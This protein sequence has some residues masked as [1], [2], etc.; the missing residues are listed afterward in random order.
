MACHGPGGK[1]DMEPA[2]QGGEEDRLP[3][4]PGPAHEGTAETGMMPNGFPLNPPM[5][6]FTDI[7]YTVFLYL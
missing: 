3:L 4:L 1:G 5:G 2:G 7:V 6:D